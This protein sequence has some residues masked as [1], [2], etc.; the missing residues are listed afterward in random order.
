M[1][2]FPKDAMRMLKETSRTFYIPITFLQKELKSAVASAYLIFRAIDEIE[3][4]EQLSND[5][6][7]DILMQVSE[8]FKKPFDNEA[9]IQILGEHK[10]QLPEVSIRLEEWLQA[11]P[12]EAMPIVMDAAR[13]MAY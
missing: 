10:N 5:V 9:Y 13:E 2:K 7:H 1:K 12:Q 8:L 3:D 4:D 6:K 11:C